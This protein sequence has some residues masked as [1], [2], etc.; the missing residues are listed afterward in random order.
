M[1]R[2]ETYN[3]AAEE[4]QKINASELDS[5]VATANL[6]SIM[7]P[8]EIG[9][10]EVKLI[11]DATG[12]SEAFVDE[13]AD[14]CNDACEACDEG[15]KPEEVKEHF[16]N[17]AMELCNKYVESANFSAPE[18]EEETPAEEKVLQVAQLTTLVDDELLKDKPAEV[19]EVISE[20]TDAPV[21][22][23]SEI[24]ESA[25]E[26][27]SNDNRF[28]IT[29]EQVAN[30]ANIFYKLGKATATSAFEKGAQETAAKAGLEAGV[31]A[32]AAINAKRVA[33]GKAEVGTS[34]LINVMKKAKEEQTAAAL[35]QAYTSRGKKVALIGAGAAAGVGGTGAT[36][37]YLAGKGKSNYAN[38]EVAEVAEAVEETIVPEP[39][40][41]VAE[42]TLKDGVTTDKPVETI[43]Q[44]PEKAAEMDPKEGDKVQDTTAAEAAL[45]VQNDLATVESAADVTPAQTNF[46]RQNLTGKEVTEG[47]KS[48]LGAR[49]IPNK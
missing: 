46:G 8:K 10:D 9:D 21:E 25:K 39:T 19:A 27:F 34:K 14:V 37:G 49:Y 22:A 6:I 43:A 20:A 15:H 33:Q 4:E 28:Y 30:F 32:K 17:V 16:S 45:K 31:A 2:R 12:A 3:F 13:M 11:S 48:L 18:K 47:L 36:A 5:A 38:E 24:V 29:T 7:D 23:V 1:R 35:E 41:L 40:T 26:Q 44:D 42:G